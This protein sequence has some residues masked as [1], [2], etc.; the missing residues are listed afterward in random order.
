MDSYERKTDR[1]RRTRAVANKDLSREM[2]Y[3]RRVAKTNK[4]GRIQSISVMGL[5][6][7]K[8]GRVAVDVASAKEMQ[9]A[10][11][12]ACHLAGCRLERFPIWDKRTV[13]CDV[14]GKHG[15]ARVLIR[16]APAGTGIVAGGTMQ[17]ILES[18]GLKDAVAKVLRGRNKINIAYATIDALRSLRASVDLNRR[19]QDVSSDTE[20]TAPTLN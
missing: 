16:R 8:A 2:L 12:K 10:L 19:A 7:D 5:V 20:T 6:G 17:L 4:R 15:V 3:Q 11:R 18:L 13:P 1:P 14:Y 9:E